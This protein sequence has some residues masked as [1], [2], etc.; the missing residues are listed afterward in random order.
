MSAQTDEFKVVLG[1]LPC[2]LNADQTQTNDVQHI[3][4]HYF[5]VPLANG[6]TRAGR[7]KDFKKAE[8]LLY[9]YLKQLGIKV[10]EPTIAENAHPSHQ[11]RTPLVCLKSRSGL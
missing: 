5:L 2:S 11:H 7:L 1:A 8:A 4:E 3:W 9:R 6:M 10:H